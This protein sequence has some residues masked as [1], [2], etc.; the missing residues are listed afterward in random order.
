MSDILLYA[1]DISCEFDYKVLNSISISLKSSQSVAIMGVSG[2]GKSTLLHTLSTFLKPSSGVVSYK[3]RDIYS[4]KKS[5]LLKI[6]REEIGFI[7]Q[8]HYLFR[9]FN[10]FENLKVSSILCNKE[11][12]KNL[13]S[14]FGLTNLLNQNIGTLSGGQQQRVSILRILT[15]KP[16]I[17]FADEPTGNLD[18][19]SAKNVISLLCQYTKDSKSA[20]LVAT[21]DRDVATMC[22]E[23]YTLRDGRLEVG[24][25]S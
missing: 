23:V 14:R 16:K 17:I 22:D 3:D 9:G 15:K 12:D 24:A 21:H 10:A 20:L 11:I 7:F 2:S 25:I 13:V 6:R 19:N 8:S 18:K 5:E 1:K 4:L